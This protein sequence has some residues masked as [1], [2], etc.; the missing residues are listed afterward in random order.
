M[1]DIIKTALGIVL[2]IF[3]GSFCVSAT[4]SC[5]KKGQYGGFGV[6]VMVSLTFIFLLF[7]GIILM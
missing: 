4:V 3:L 2:T 7:R 1:W 5:Y 6:G